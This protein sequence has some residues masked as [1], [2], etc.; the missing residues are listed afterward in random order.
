[1][2]IESSKHRRNDLLLKAG[3]IVLAF[4]LFSIISFIAVPISSVLIVPTI[5][6]I[7]LDVLMSVVWGGLVTL[8]PLA[9]TLILCGA[10]NCQNDINI[11]KADIN[12]AKADINIAKADI[13]IVSESLDSL[14]EPKK[15][16]SKDLVDEKQNDCDESKDVTAKAG[17]TAANSPGFFSPSPGK[18]AENSNTATN[19]VDPIVCVAV[20]KF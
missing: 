15:T 16:S 3:G 7:L 6:S 11:A 8:F 19:I 20:S 9:L 13:N 14:N 18:D 1:M 17:V 5:V 10:S 2:S 4:L 12:I